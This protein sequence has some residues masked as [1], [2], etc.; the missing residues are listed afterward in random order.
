MSTEKSW[1]TIFDVQFESRESYPELPSFERH[2]TSLLDILR[3]ARDPK[4]KPFEEQLAWRKLIIAA[5]WYFKRTKNDQKEL[6]PSRRVERLL[7]DFVKP[8]RRVLG[9]AQK[10]LQD[11]VGSDLSRG[12]WAETKGSDTSMQ[13]VNAVADEITDAFAKV[14]ALEAAAARAARDL[15]KKVGARSETG[16]LS[17]HD[18]INLRSLYRQSTGR[19][20]RGR[21]FVEFVENFLAAVGQGDAT[22]QDYVVDALKYAAKKARK[23][24][25]AGR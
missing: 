6:L 20:P 16:I 8:L 15:P 10:A 21:L 11:D 5:V 14:A 1:H 9:G 18:I 4:S 24:K 17:M 23:S 2:K 22:E 12:W 13:A 7:H 19:E 25:S 3:K